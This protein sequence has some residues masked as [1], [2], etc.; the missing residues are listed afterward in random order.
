M[1]TQQQA[2]KQ[3]QPVVEQRKAKT[4]E[5]SLDQ[6]ETEKSMDSYEDQEAKLID[7]KKKTNELLERFLK[8]QIYVSERDREEEESEDM[9]SSKFESRQESRQDSRFQQQQH[10]TDNDRSQDDNLT[11]D[12][13]QSLLESK[14]SRA[15]FEPNNFINPSMVNNNYKDVPKKLQAF[16]VELSPEQRGR[17]RNNRDRDVNEDSAS[18]L[19]YSVSDRDRSEKKSAMERSLELV[20]NKGQ[21]SNKTLMEFSF[22]NQNMFTNKLG[23]TGALGGTAASKK[24]SGKK[25]AQPK[26][27]KTEI[28][29]YDKENDNSMANSENSNKSPVA[30]NK[31]MSLAE[32]FKRNRKQFVEK[33]DQQQKQTGSGVGGGD[34]DREEQ[35]Q[36]KETKGKRTKEEILKQRKEMMEYRGP[37]TK[38]RNESHDDNQDSEST[39]KRT[40]KSTDDFGF[41]TGKSKNSNASSQQDPNAELMSRLALGQKTKVDKKEMKALTQKNY[42]LLPEVKKRKEE[43]KKKEDFKKR[44]DNMKKLDQKVRSNLTKTSLK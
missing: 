12:H 32:M 38:K 41:K 37:I 5:D 33:Y 34:R 36:P 3:P 8:P 22:K 23:G 24:S 27:W 20:Q 19:N 18:E 10:Y 43:E 4:P 39:A 17:G 11:S 31:E 21:E 29:V 25:E 44:Q 1:K 2:K 6:S 40:D 28:N 13:S 14:Q 15:P 35:Q 26:P 30:E 7:M 42:E 16:T 9:K